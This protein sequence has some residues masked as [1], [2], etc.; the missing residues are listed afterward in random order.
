MFSLVEG[1]ERIP[2][3]KFI[4]LDN[5]TILNND[6]DIFATIVKQYSKVQKDDES[7]REN[8]EEEVELEKVLV[9]KAFDALE[10]L[11]LFKLQQEDMPQETLRALDQIEGEL[12]T[13]RVSTRKQTTINSFFKRK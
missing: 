5:K 1:Q 9:S 10:T 8:K 2:L 7:D 4:N 6:L 13:V 11:R 12:A 3:N